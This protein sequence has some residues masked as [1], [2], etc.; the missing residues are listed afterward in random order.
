MA[1]D[2]IGRHQRQALPLA[3]TLRLLKLPPYVS[4]SFVVVTRNWRV[5][6]KAKPERKAIEKEGHERI[7]VLGLGRDRPVLCPPL[8]NPLGPMVR[9]NK[10]RVRRS[11][12]SARTRHC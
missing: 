9:Q 11:T 3:N 12:S 6:Q 10:S 2:S 1:L 7:H 5:R 8:A 4:F